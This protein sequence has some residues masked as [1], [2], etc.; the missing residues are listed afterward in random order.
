PGGATRISL[1]GK[2]VIP[3]LINAHGHPGF[4][5]G[6]SY[7][8]DNFTREN[9]MDDLNRALYF[10]VAVVQSQGIEKGEVTYQIRADQDAGEL[11]GARLRIAGRGIGAPNAGPGGAAYAG[12]A[13]EVTT[14]E[15]GRRAVRE[16]AAKKVNL[17][18]I[19]VDDRNGRAPR[20]A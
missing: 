13:Y 15:Q 16:L 4:Q 6:L 10:G 11:G 2:T 3:T 12:I 7:S 1:A 8:A 5:R 19:W 18:K 9:I 17:I 14:E 20:L